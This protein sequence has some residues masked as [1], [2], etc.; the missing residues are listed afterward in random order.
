MAKAIPFCCSFMWHSTP[1]DITQRHVA[2]ML[3]GGIPSCIGCVTWDKK[4]CTDTR[5]GAKVATSLASLRHSLNS[6]S[7]GPSCLNTSHGLTLAC[8]S[9]RQ[10]PRLD[11]ALA[12]RYLPCAIHSSL[13]HLDS[14]GIWANR[15]YSYCL[16]S[17]CCFATV[18]RYRARVC[19]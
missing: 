3:G 7:P 13:Q 11:A 1:C 6:R 4:K 5:A 12:K 19:V 10:K 2:Y 15:L 9:G 14:S 16:T 17:V 8:S 18:L